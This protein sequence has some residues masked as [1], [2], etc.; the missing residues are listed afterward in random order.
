MRLDDLPELCSRDELAQFLGI[1]V[2]TLARWAMAKEGPRVTKIGHAV[3]Y[4]KADVLA[5][6]EA[7]AA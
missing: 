4:R 7:S 5:Y 3:R 2:G 6:I 1:S